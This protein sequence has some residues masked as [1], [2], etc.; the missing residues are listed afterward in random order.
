MAPG[1]ENLYRNVPERCPVAILLIDVIN[2]FEFE[3]GW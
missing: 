3:G 1:S 2:D